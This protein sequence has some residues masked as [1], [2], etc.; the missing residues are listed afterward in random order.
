MGDSAADPPQKK[1]GQHSFFQR[2]LSLLA[3]TDD[4]E[5]IKRRQLKQI[6]KELSR[7]KYRFYKPRTGQALPGL[8]KFFFEI[9]KTIGPAQALLQGSE[10]SKALKAILIDTY[11]TDE[12][13]DARERFSEDALREAARKM[14]PDQLAAEVKEAMR[15]YLSGFSSDVVKSINDT[16]T[17]IQ[18]LIEFVRFDYYFAL[19]KFDSAMV[20]G[21]FSNP[22]RAEPINAEYISDDLKDFL[23]VLLPLDAGADWAMAIEGLA[24]YK[25]VEVVNANEWKK[26]LNSLSSVVRSGVLVQIIRHV[27]KD[28]SYRP[29]ARTERHHIVESH[30]NILKTQV[31]G[32]VQKIMREIRGSK[33]EQMAVAVFGTGV[34]QRLGNYSEKANAEFTRRMIAG[35]AHVQ[36]LNYLA[37]FLFDYYNLDVRLLISEMFIVRAKWSDNTVSGQLSEAYGEVLTVSESLEEF[38]LAVGEEGELGAKLKKALAPTRESESSTVRK[39]RQIVHDIDERAMNLIRAAGTNLITVARI[40]KM[41][42]EDYERKEPEYIMNWRELE[43]FS[44]ETIRG[45]LVSVYKKIYHFIQLLQVFVKK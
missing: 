24:R 16:Y 43:S 14:L 13:N 27:D 31:E 17:L 21:T 45:Q 34:V 8:S 3:G 12:Q 36:A 39:V 7:Q 11:H 28:P 18:Q 15:V 38:E 4:E 40:I 6:G 25:S 29:L 41:L 26:L 35:F 1:P 19:K 2:F 22:P 44:T 5:R 32:N 23:E 10:N 37:A 42:V 9:Y 33:I 20:E 30:L